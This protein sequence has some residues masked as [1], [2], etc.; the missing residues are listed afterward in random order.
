MLKYP[1]T[2]HLQGSR[3]QNG[4]HDLSQVSLAQLRNEALVVVEEKV[5]GANAGISFIDDM[6]MLQSRG[7]Y[8]TG[9]AREKHFNLFKTWAATHEVAL[10]EILGERYIM[11]GEWCYAKHTVFYDQLPHY[12]LEF[13]IYDQEKSVFLSTRERHAMLAGSPVVSVPVLW[14]GTGAQF[15]TPHSLVENSLYKS[16]DWRE[17]LHTQA[18]QNGVDAY[19]AVHETDPHD[20]SEGLYLK[21]EDQAAG[22]TTGRLKWVRASFLNA[23]LDSGTHW[24]SRPI[25]PN[26]LHP[27]V[28]IWKE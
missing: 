15:P 6:L 23:I 11:Y 18:V 5:D 16:M 25:V 14:Q 26:M 1:R 12:F 21:I 28:D 3:L 9:G 19:R 17:A 2:Q 7:H 20:Q 4:D 22:T 27:D 8:L 10:Y 13:D 24:L